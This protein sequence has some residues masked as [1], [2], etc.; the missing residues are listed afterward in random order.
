MYEEKACG[1]LDKNTVSNIEQVLEA[2]NMQER[3]KLRDKILKPNI[4]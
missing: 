3:P 2:N 4:C 1:Q